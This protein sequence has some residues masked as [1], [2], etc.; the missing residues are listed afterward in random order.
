[1]DIRF[2][3]NP[4]GMV[5]IDVDRLRPLV[6]SRSNSPCEAAAMTAEPPSDFRLASTPQRKLYAHSRI[7]P[8]KAATHAH[9]MTRKIRRRNR[10][11]TWLHFRTITPESIERP[12]LYQLRSSN[13]VPLLRERK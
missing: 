1:M 5:S 7:V 13:S 3:K 11:A 6:Y 8:T 10:L 12:Y 9:L 2:I 4:N